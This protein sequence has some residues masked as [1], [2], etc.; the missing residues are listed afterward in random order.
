MIK[1]IVRQILGIQNTEHKVD[2]L[3]ESVQTKRDEVEKKFRETNQVINDTAYKISI[4]TRI[5]K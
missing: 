3:R 5:R 2:T 1:E 4:A